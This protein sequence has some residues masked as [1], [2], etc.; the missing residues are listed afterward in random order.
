SCYRRSAR[1][2]QDATGLAPWSAHDRCY[3]RSTR[4]PQDATGLSRGVLT[5]GATGARRTRHKMPRAWP[6]GVLTLVATGARHA[7][8]KMP[9]DVPVADNVILH[10]T[11]R[12]HLQDEA[13]VS[14][15][16]ASA[17]LHG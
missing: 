10:R 4:T 2:P 1:T 17:N 14:C 15:V 13:A 8:H 9:L 12:W 11:S 3:R 16:A 5:I 6:R 7:R